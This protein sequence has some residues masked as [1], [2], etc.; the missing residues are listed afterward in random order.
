MLNPALFPKNKAGFSHNRTRV[1]LLGWGLAKNFILCY[2]PAMLTIKKKQSIVKEFGKDVKDT[3][4]PEVQ[5]ALLSEQITEL[6]KHLQIHKK[7]G[8]SRRGLVKMVA[9]RRTLLSYLK[10]KDLKSYEKVT[11]KMGLK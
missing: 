7:D 2:D 9:D 1:G 11:K 8:H 6:T 10:K 5:I 3:G 4:S